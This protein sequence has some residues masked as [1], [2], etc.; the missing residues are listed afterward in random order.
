MAIVTRTGQGYANPTTSQAPLAVFARAHLKAI[1]STIAVANGDSATSVYKIGKV[2]TSAIID[3]ASL[4]YASGIA[5]L[6]SMSFGV[7]ASSSQ[8]QPAN[9]IGSWAASPALFVNAQDWH[10][11]ASFSLYGNVSVAN[12]GK[13][14][15]ELLGLSFDPGG[16]VD[17]IATVNQA[18]GA[19]GQLQFVV[20]YLDEK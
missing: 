20:K 18:A 13:R 15:W 10:T 4:V 9:P 19:A 8:Q 11:A 5:G 12:Y 7:D 1:V 16:E 3:P 2:P 17:L 6:T 14:I